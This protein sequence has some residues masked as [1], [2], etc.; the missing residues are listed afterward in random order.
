VPLLATASC[1][2]PDPLTGPPRP[3]REVVALRGAISA[4]QILIYR[5]K[6]VIAAY[7]SLARSLEPLLSQH[8]AH[9]AQLRGRLI[10]PPAASP[11][12]SKP[13]PVPA[14]P[15][16]AADAAA[17]LQAA[18]RNAAAAQVKRLTA[19]APS[20]AQLLASIAACEATH[21]AALAPLRQAR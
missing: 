16:S 18:E 4:E 2:G 9:L 13:A 14:V 12:P 7:Q 1:V 15:G 3:S 10:E 17:F 19:V 20:L 8:D 5:Y 21:V 6:A 11:S